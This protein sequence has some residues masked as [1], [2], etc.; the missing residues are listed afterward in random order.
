VSITASL[1]A[2]LVTVSG[3]PYQTVVALPPSSLDPTPGK[4]RV[5]ISGTVV[6]RPYDTTMEQP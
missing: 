4:I 3:A 6:E 1:V 2:E 5:V